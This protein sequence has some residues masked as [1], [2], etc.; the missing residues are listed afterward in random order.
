MLTVD[1]L[2]MSYGEARRRRARQDEQDGAGTRVYAVG[3]ATF[4]VH[5]GELFTLLGPSGCGKT[6]TLRSIAGLENPDEGRICVGDRV[7]FDA[8]NRVN[9][10]ANRRE[11]GMVSSP[12]PS[13]RT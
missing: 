12:T 11:L 9:V 13:G 10:P 4:E 1:N 5:D 3:G 7:L 2:K 6:T 8:G